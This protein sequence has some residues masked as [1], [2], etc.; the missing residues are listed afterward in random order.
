MGKGPKPVPLPHRTCQI[1]PALPAARLNELRALIALSMPIITVQVGLMAMN[2]VDVMMVGRLSEGALAAVTLGNLWVWA[3]TVFCM[4]VVMA[5]DPLISQA[6]GAG[7]SAGVS[8]A[9]QGG[10]CIAVLLSL[11][12][13]L[14]V[15]PVGHVL[16]LAQ[17]P[18]SVIPDATAYAH[19]SIPGI[20]PRPPCALGTATGMLSHGFGNGDS[21]C[22][23]QFVPDTASAPL[24]KTYL[25]LSRARS[26]LKAALMRAKWVKAWGKLP[27]ASPVG[28]ISS[29]YRPKWLA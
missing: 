4:G 10:L 24:L 12:G 28:P 23:H 29:A 11:P 16:T 15:L 20:L 3:A 21:G 13:A 27:R 18:A 5:A 1:R 19:T 17:Q 2:T 9:V 14:L 6:M 25:C 8:R 7:D 26:R 22:H